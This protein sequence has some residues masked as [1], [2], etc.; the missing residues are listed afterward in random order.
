M[1]SYVWQGPL[2]KTGVIDVFKQ[3]YLTPSIGSEFSDLD[4]AEALKSP[5]ADTLFRDLAITSKSLSG[6]ISIASH[7]DVSQFPSVVLLYSV[8][9]TSTMK[10]TRKSS[11]ALPVL[12]VAQPRMIL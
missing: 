4:L 2:T 7:Q 9:N 11:T 10:P 8:I 1:S 5:N 6:I 12:P 3:K